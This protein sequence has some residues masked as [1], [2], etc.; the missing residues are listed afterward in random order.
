[1][2][3]PMEHAKLSDFDSERGLWKQKETRWLNL[4]IYFLDVKLL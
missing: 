4:N 1:M 3:F 2:S